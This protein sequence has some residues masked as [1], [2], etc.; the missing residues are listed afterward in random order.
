LCWEQDCMRLEEAVWHQ[1]VIAWMKLMLLIVNNTRDS[2]SISTAFDK[3]QSEAS[4][5]H[6]EF[7]MDKVF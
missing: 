2:Y 1:M 5:K 4:G 3:I 7:I 6:W